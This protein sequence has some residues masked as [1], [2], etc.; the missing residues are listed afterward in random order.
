MTEPC[1]PPWRSSARQHA[2][3]TFDMEVM[4]QAYQAIYSELMG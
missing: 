4:L 3:S 2:L 1:V